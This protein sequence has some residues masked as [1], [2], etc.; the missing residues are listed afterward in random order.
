MPA[1]LGTDLLLQPGAA[2]RGVRAALPRGDAEH[3]VQQRQQSAA[4]TPGRHGLQGALA[5]SYS[6]LVLK[7]ILTHK[8][9]SDNA[10]TPTNDMRYD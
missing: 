4:G 1:Y 9:I 6:L 7:R 10:Q 8:N 2:L 5:L 3:R